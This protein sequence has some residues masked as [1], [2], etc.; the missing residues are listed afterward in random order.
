MKMKLRVFHGIRLG[1]F[2]LRVVEI[3][4]FGSGKYY[5]GMSLNASQCCK[6]IHKM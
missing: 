4:L 6:D 5:L 3:N 2:L 1:L